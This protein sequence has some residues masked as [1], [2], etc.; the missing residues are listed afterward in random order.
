MKTLDKLLSYLCK[1]NIRGW[2]RLLSFFRNNAINYPIKSKTTHG[3]TFLL[4]VKDKPD[5]DVLTRGYYEEEVLEAILEH[6]PQGGVFWDIG[7][8]IGTHGLTVLKLRSDCQV[9]CFEPN[10][11]TFTRLLMNV[12]ENNLS[13]VLFNTALSNK[14]GFAPL[15]LM[16]TEAGG[17]TS[18]KPWAGREYEAKTNI[19]AERADRICPQHAPLPNIIKMDVEGFELEVLEGFGSLL[20]EKLLKA[21]IFEAPKDFLENKDSYPLYRFLSKAGFD[22]VALIPQKKNTRANNFIAVR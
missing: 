11:S 20:N 14:S 3:L 19:Y 10:P 8:H 6:L 2:G 1:R 12:R 22:I 21:I 7:T 13:P 5:W 17:K 18:L 15:S 16:L 4:D 9:A